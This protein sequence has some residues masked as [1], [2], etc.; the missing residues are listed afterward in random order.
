MVTLTSRVLDPMFRITHHVCRP[1]RR[2]GFMVVVF[3]SVS[4]IGVN[5]VKGFLSV[6]R[7][8]AFAFSYVS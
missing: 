8:F 5:M 1:Q 6:Y 2:V 4:N 3:S 7:G